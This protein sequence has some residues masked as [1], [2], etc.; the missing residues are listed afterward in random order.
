[1]SPEKKPRAGALDE[2]I[3]DPKLIR[4]C[5]AALHAEGTE[6]P[7]KVEG[8]STLPYSSVV[9]LLEPEKGQCVL[10]LVRPLP[11]ELLKGALFRMV[12]AVGDQRYEGLITFQGREAYL[13]YRFDAP[14]AIQYSDR[15]RHRRHPF[16][17]REKAYVTGQDGGVP[18]IGIAGPLANIGL[19]GCAIRLDRVLRMSDGLRIPV[20][21]GLFDRG[22]LFAK[23][24]IQD[25]LKVAA[26]DLRGQVAHL[27]DRG[28][29]I[30]LGLAFGELDA[31]E[32]QLLGD[33]L[34]LRE[35]M[36]RTSGGGGPR[37]DAAPTAPRPARGS[38][39]PEAP[40]PVPTGA[41]DL[42]AA[43]PP[44]GPLLQLQRHTTGLLLAMTPGE[45]RDRIRQRLLDQGF[46]RLQ[47]CDDLEGAAR[48]FQDAPPVLRP[49]ALV[50]DL[51]LGARNGE[52]EPLALLR[53]VQRKLE[54]VK[55]LRIYALCPE[56]EPS[57][58]LEQSPE[59]RVG[60]LDP[61]DPSTWAAA[62]D[63]LLELEDRASVLAEGSD[64]DH[65]ALGPHAE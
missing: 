41:P 30:L 50:A 19:G 2:P 21:T 7:I 33:T 36:F 49:K 59:I 61:K 22:K 39:L 18:G 20:N 16:R 9:Q 38:G 1:M 17:P 60:L 31:S 64:P 10:K 47:I 51:Q 3:E 45:G 13:Q 29:G 4:E 25:L 44:P 42:P 23:L 55:D 57:L 32:L 40:A 26:L 46:H 54:S 6:F 37:P 27:T 35:K 63:E 24:R 11:H 56:V 14:Q 58:A 34:T 52:V 5:L 48:Q 53:E 28:D 43:H 15:R 65:L 12:F 8:A 62:L